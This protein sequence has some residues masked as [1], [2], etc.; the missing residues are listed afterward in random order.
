MSGVGTVRYRH[1]GVMSEDGVDLRAEVGLL[2]RNIRI[3]GE[4]EESCY[5]N[6]LCDYFNYDTFGGHMQVLYTQVDIRT[7]VKIYRYDRY[8]A[9]VRKKINQYTLRDVVARSQPNLIKRRKNNLENI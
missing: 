5:D 4:M 1:L 3:H 2:S 6:N 7:Q 8:T 9:R